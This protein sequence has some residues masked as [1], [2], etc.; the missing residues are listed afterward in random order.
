LQ[1]VGIAVFSK[2]LVGLQGEVAFVLDEKN[3]SGIIDLSYKLKDED[4]RAGVLTEMGLSLIKEVGN[5]V[6][7]SYLNAL[8][9][10]FRRIIVPSLPTMVSGLM[11]DILNILLSSYDEKDESYVVETTF[12]VPNGGL[13]GSFYFFITPSTVKDIRQVCQRLIEKPEIND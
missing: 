12:V 6:I 5:V 9:L 8:S 2:V 4:K 13:K 3:A 1:K 10:M 7:G 11:D